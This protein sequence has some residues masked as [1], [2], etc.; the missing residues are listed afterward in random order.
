MTAIQHQA[1]NPI[2]HLT[3][4]DVEALGHELDALREEIL[5]T[6]GER[7]AA[8][9]RKVIGVQRRLELGSRAVLLASLF[10]PAWIVGTA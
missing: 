4:E 2:A 10:P 5:C 6:R 8:Y 1:V 7:D 9:I 3:A